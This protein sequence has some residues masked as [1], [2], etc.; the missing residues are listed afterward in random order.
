MMLDQKKITTAWRVFVI[1]V[2]IWRWFKR[3]TAIKIVDLPQP[4]T[5]LMEGPKPPSYFVSNGST[6][7]PDRVFGADL[8]R[9]GQ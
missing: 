5:S 2:R 7:S 3:P 1:L 9:A 8:R 6:F 4:I